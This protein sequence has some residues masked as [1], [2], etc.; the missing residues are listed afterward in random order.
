MMSIMTQKLEEN[1]PKLFELLKT[2]ELAELGRDLQKEEVKEVYNKVL[3]IHEFFSSKEFERCKVKKGQRI[4]DESNTFL[5]SKE[6]FDRLQK[7][8]SPIMVE[9]KITD[10]KGYYIQNWSM[11]AC[12][13]RN[14]LVNFIII[15]LVPEQFRSMFWKQRLSI[16]FQ[17]KLIDIFRKSVA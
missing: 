4:T 6:D 15:N 14:A 3:S 8:A 16:I 13:A 1:K 17:D 2:L 12:D 9:R 11:I 5:L 10:E 7:L